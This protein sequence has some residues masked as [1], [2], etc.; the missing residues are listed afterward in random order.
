MSLRDRILG[1]PTD[2]QNLRTTQAQ[3]FDAHDTAAADGFT[4]GTP[5]YQNVDNLNN[6]VNAIAARVPRWR[7]GDR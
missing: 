6:Q 3:L 7:G 1:N 5:S 4:P 2:I